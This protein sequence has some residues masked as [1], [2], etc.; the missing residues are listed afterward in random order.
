MS[1]RPEEPRQQSN[2]KQEVLSNVSVGGNLTIGNINQSQNGSPQLTQEDRDEEKF[3]NR[4]LTALHES[5]LHIL[6]KLSLKAEIELLL[7]TRSEL[8]KNPFSDKQDKIDAH[9]QIQALRKFSLNGK[10][11]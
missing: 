8:D 2:A 6:E 4:L 5:W 3:R 11:D 9:L 10:M 1:N 7:E